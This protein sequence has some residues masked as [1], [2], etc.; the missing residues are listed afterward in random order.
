MSIYKII[1]VLLFVLTFFNLQAYGQEFKADVTP[2]IKPINKVINIGPCLIEDSVFFNFEFANKGKKSLF[3]ERLSPSFYLGAAPSDLSAIQF[4]LYRELPIL[5]LILNPAQKDTMIV[6]FRAGDTV[7]T[8]PGW[9]QALLALSFYDGDTKKAPP[10]TPI[11]TFLLTVKKTI[12]HFD[13]FE[14]II[15]FDSVYINPNTPK[16]MLWRGK[17]TYFKDILLKNRKLSYITQPQIDSEFEL[18]ELLENLTIIPDGIINRQF[19]YKPNNMGYDTAIVTNFFVPNLNKN[20][21]SLDSSSVKL[22]GIGVYQD[23]SL[24]DANYDFR[25]DTLFIGDILPNNNTQLII[26]LKNTGNIPIFAKSEQ[27][28]NLVNNKIS[29]EFSFV[30]KFQNNNTYLQK[31]STCKIYLDYNPKNRGLCIYN[32]TIETNLMERNIHGTPQSQSKINFYIVANLVAPNMI[33]QND[34]LDFGNIALNNAYCPTKRDTLLKFSNNG[35]S[36]LSIYDIK[37]D[38]EYPQSPFRLGAYDQIL[39]PSEEGKFSISFEEISPQVREY[40]SILTFSTNES[41]PA[42]VH[43]V[44]IKANTIP[45]LSGNIS[46]PDNLRAKP[47]RVIEVPIQVSYNGDNP[48]QFAEKFKANIIYNKSLLEYLGTTTLNTACE[49]SINKSDNYEGD[50]PEI[51]LEFE[52]STNNNFLNRDTIVKLR[53]NTYLG[54]AISTEIAI[55]NPQFSDSK[56]TNL[57]K[58]QINNGVFT[59]DSVCGIEYKAVQKPTQQLQIN[60]YYKQNNR[61]FEYSIPYNDNVELAMY[62][63][64]GN[65][66]KQLFNQLMPSGVYQFNLNDNEFPNGSYYIIIRNKYAFDSKQFI[67]VK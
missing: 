43:K 10:I 27:I 55:I 59:T 58:L 12:K 47:G 56:C 49:G 31:D 6:A 29:D 48:I 54:N 2:F 35:N 11:D 34:S 37:L 21:D 7:V 67:I 53:F 3:M 24:E 28:I 1:I 33:I 40:E 5:P 26:T 60:T 61:I 41:V 13:N 52:A 14:D 9:H 8:K 46:I 66:I 15:D 38:P 22:I 44:L 30:T 39:E 23:L 42:K 18:G 65:K 51:K 4:T 25:N 17:N 64:Y 20:K 50:N 62:D 36:K 45:P 16:S 57:F 32:Y 63:I 19:K